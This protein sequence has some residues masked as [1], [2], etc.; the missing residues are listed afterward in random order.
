LHNLSEIKYVLTSYCEIYVCLYCAEIEPPSA[1]SV[2]MFCCKLLLLTTVLWR[3]IDFVWK[4]CN[5]YCEPS[6]CYVSPLSPAVGESHIVELRYIECRKDFVEEGG[7]AA[8]RRNGMFC[9]D[10]HQQSISADA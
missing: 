9:M 6:A 1:G 8:I 2:C 10:E 4:R 7:L 5:C 3:S